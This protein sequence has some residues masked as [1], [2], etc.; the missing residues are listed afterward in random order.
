MA[1]VQ[2]FEESDLGLAELSLVL[3]PKINF[4]TEGI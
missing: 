1:V 4:N 2:V 3:F